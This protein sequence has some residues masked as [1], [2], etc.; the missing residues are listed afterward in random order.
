MAFLLLTSPSLRTQT[1][2]SRPTM[3]DVVSYALHFSPD[4]QSA[5]LQIDS[6]R[7]EQRIARALPNPT[8]TVTP[9]TPFQYTVS[10]PI[11]IG[12]DRFFRTR[13]ANHGAA[14]VRFDAQNTTRQVVF[15]ARQGFL[16][17]QLAEATRDIAAEQDTIVRRLL[18]T[19]SV[20]FYSGDLAQ[21]DLNTTELQYAHAEATLARADA[22]AR[23][24]RINLQILIGVPHPDT[25]FRIS[26]KLEYHPIELPLD[27][28]RGLALE[29]R[30]DI[31]AA[32]ERV[33]QSK[34]LR[35][36]ANSLVLPVPGLAAVY[37]PQPF[38]SGSKYAV[39][40]SL[41][42][43]ILY[44]LGGERER[45]TAGLRSAEVAHQRAITGIE[46]EV[47]AAVGN[48]RATRTL[49]ARYATGLLDKSR[50]TLEMQRF[51]YE[52]G[53]ASLLDLL[54]AISAFGDTESDYYTAL[55]DYWVAAYAIDRAV[56]RDVIP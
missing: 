37:Q 10:E 28:L 53:N 36:L 24:A 19:D 9:G 12:P 4:L 33:N 46:G 21:R 52:H 55:H 27:S 26:G 34:S 22:G 31:G 29:E 51:A 16:D 47:T 2:Y 18:Q 44:W 38:Q 8:F 13:A 56:G 39:G 1:A 14:A 20:R 17:L 35:A 50:V 7:G 54:N 42:V 23:A 49:A 32:H 48:L 5:R 40:I 25:S 6:A 41:T 45:A 43:P 30:P 11:D 3:H 15:S